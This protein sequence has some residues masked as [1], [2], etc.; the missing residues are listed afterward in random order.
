[1][2]HKEKSKFL[3]ENGWYTLW[4]DDNWLES[5]KEYSN[6]DCAGMTTDQAYD[7]EMLKWKHNE[8]R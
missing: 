6:P 2:T 8:L 4:S 7:E 3:K 1:M 5:D